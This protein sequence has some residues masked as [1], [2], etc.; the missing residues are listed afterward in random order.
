MS[1]PLTKDHLMVNLVNLFPLPWEG[2]K[3]RQSHVRDTNILENKV[4]LCMIVANHSLLLNHHGCV[5][6]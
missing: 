3:P 5:I 4:V 6:S 1:M 2:Y